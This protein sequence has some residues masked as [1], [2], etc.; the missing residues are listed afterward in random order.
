M[1]WVVIWIRLSLNSTPI[2][3]ARLL[4]TTLSQKRR[5]N[6][7]KHSCNYSYTTIQLIQTDEIR[8]PNRKH[9]NKPNIQP[10]QTRSKLKQHK[11]YTP[12]QERKNRVRSNKYRN[13]I[14]RREKNSKRG[15]LKKHT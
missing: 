15:N 7:A 3:D 6:L 11:S 8:H 9:P 1:L 12:R 5:N 14:A 13:T 4:P 10:R 2:I